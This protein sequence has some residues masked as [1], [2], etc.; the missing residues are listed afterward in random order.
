MVPQ[1]TFFCSKTL[2]NGLK[3]HPKCLFH[4]FTYYE[5]Q[6]FGG[7]SPPHLRAAGCCWRG[8]VMGNNTNFL[9]F[10][11]GGPSKGRARY[12]IQSYKYK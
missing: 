2:K 7:F 3:N 5:F 1:A 9:S 11:G 10:L 4:H 8:I 12:D 6:N